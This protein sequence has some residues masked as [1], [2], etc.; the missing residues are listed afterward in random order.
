MR[1]PLVLALAILL[2]APSLAQ[3]AVCNVKL[4]ATV[5]NQCENATKAHSYIVQASMCESAAEQWSYCAPEASAVHYDAALVEQAYYLSLA[6]LGLSKAH[7]GE[8][9][10][11]NE[12]MRVSRRIAQAALKRGITGEV[13]EL[14]ETEVEAATLFFKN[15]GA[16]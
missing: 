15:H 13:K 16:R 6:G 7:V 4:L 11:A 12:H 8:D 14:A 5:V 9:V 2:L 10:R 1:K 3:A